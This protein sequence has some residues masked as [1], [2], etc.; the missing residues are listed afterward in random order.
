MRE[1]GMREGGRRG[2]R[3]VFLP[4]PSLFWCNPI[5]L[6]RTVLTTTH[7]HTHTHAQL[8]HRTGFIS[9]NRFKSPTSVYGTISDKDH[10][11]HISRCPYHLL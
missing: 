2:R 4:C 8:E 7:T 1:G 3:E 6:P 11:N 9:K 10:D 5:S